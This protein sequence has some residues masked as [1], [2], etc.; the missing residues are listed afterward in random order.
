[1]NNMLIN[2]GHSV[3]QLYAIIVDT[4]VARFEISMSENLREHLLITALLLSL[5]HI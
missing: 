1:M 4:L 3:S 5:I 2:N